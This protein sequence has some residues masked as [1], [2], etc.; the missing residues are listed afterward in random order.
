MKTLET[1]IEISASP[2]KVWSI[3]CDFQKYP[4]WNPF[5]KE[6][7]GEAKVGEKLKVRISPPH[8][9][10]MV[11]RPTVKNVIENREFSWLGRFLFPGIF[12]GEHSFNIEPTKSGALLTQKENFSGLLVPLLWRSLDRNTRE[13]FRQ[14]NEA[15]KE[16]AEDTSLS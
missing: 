5:I 10:A 14:M 15:L 4:E 3:L 16:R 7:E 6:L 11:F 9:K 13:G 8:S 1:N 12:D 2:E